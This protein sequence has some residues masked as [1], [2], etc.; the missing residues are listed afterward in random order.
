MHTCIIKKIYTNQTGFGTKWS[1]VQCNRNC[2]F[3][4]NL[5]QAITNL[6]QTKKYI[7]R[8]VRSKNPSKNFYVYQ[9]GRWPS[10]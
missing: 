5:P 4:I 9:S 1:H 10:G 6:N 3:F 7:K 2:N 8:K